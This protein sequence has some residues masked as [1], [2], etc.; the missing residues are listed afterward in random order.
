[1]ASLHERL[2]AG[3]D[4]RKVIEQ[5]PDPELMSDDMLWAE[6]HQ[7]TDLDEQSARRWACGVAD[8]DGRPHLGWLH[9]HARAKQRLPDWEWTTWL[10]LTGRGW[11]KTLTAAQAVRE[12]ARKPGQF[13]AVVAKNET[14]VREICFEHKKSGLLAVIPDDEVASYSKSQG[15]VHMVL[16]N[17]T[18]IRGFGA[19]TPDNLRG[20]AFDKVW[21]DEYAAWNR[22]TAQ[23]VMDMLWFCLR[24]S[25]LPQVVVSTTPKPLPHI[26]KLVRRNKR[27]TERMIEDAEAYANDPANHQAPPP[28]PRVVLTVGHTDENRD[29]LSDAALDELHGEFDDRRLGDQELGGLL[30]E[31]VEG[32]LWK[33]WMFEGEGFRIPWSHVPPIERMV[34]AVDPATTTTETA[35]E[36]GI[37]VCGRGPWLD[38]TYRDQRPRGFVFHSEAKK[39]TPMQTMRRAAA[40]YHEYKADAVILEANNGGEYLAT[41]LRLVDPTVNYRIVHAVRD[42]RA[43]AVP[44]AALYEQE[45]VHHVGELL[46]DGTVGSKPL[47]ALEEVQTTY[48]GAPDRE[49]KSPDILDALVWAFWDLFLDPTAP[50][51]VTGAGYGRDRRNEG[52]R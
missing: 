24:E 2:A 23:A 21:A 46:T 7:L 49:E 12:W 34:V 8:C 14:L 30:L 9:R 41:V 18:V 11:G 25:E 15:N 28:G 37:A 33:R 44:V 27:Q 22:H 42:K 51:A 47:A 26:V 35:D 16:T 19:E 13:I 38:D 4:K 52:R 45:R 43:R 17:G 29:N 40:L 3:Y 39:L 50:G 10:M 32:S 31:D 5:L 36:S 6:I 20:W 48:V 1:M